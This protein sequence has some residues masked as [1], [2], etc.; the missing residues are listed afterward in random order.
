MEILRK[1]RKDRGLTLDEVSSAIGVTSSYIS[2]IERGLKIPSLEILRSLSNYLGVS[3]ARLLES[4]DQLPNHCRCVVIPKEKRS[5]VQL[6][7]RRDNVSVFSLLP[8]GGAHGMHVYLFKVAPGKFVSGTQSTHPN[9][10]FAYVLSG[11]LEAHIGDEYHL[12]KSESSIYIQPMV[13][14]D[15]RNAGSNEADILFVLND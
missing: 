12:L 1:L 6:A 5:L 13:P 4:S 10:E 11:T 2:Q 3:I 7:S 15:Y 9:P 8:D 14:H